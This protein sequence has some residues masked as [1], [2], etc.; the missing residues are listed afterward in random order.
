MAMAQHTFST[1]SSSLL[2]LMDCGYAALDLH[3]RFLETNEALTAMFGY[4]TDTLLLM[5]IEALWADADAKASWMAQVKDKGVVRHYAAEMKHQNG[6]LVLVSLNAEYLQEHQTYI[7][8]VS[9]SLSLDVKQNEALEEKLHHISG[10][11]A[12]LINN[13]MAA[14]VN[15]ADLLKKELKHEPKLAKK[16]DRITQ[17]GFKASEVAHDLVEYTDTAESEPFQ[18]LYL[19]DL[20]PLVMQQYEQQVFAD[21]PRVFT[22]DIMKGLP[23]C[24]GNEQQIL[25]LLTCL[26][27]NAFEATKEGDIITVKVCLA[28]LKHKSTGLDEEYVMLSVQDNG[29]GM[30]EETQKHIFEPYF[31]TKF[32]GRGMSLARALKVIKKHDGRIHV[33]TGS[34]MGSLFK[35]Y[36][37]VRQAE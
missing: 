29:I 21:S 37:P 3:G 35:V 17:S 24:M 32:M 5:D 1:P 16:L 27:D 36:F 7:L 13:Q 23:S 14:V 34:N 15:T 18:P 22:Y 30:D 9:P 20:A 26:M 12:H 2:K 31:S 33:K 11:I 25:K 10:S 28:T 6:E 8:C 4:S 19:N